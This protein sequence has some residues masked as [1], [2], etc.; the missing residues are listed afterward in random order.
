MIRT[1]CDWC[2]NEITKENEFKPIVMQTED[3]R[4]LRIGLS[5][6]PEHN[7]PHACVACVI[8]AF[9]SAVKEKK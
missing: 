9:N 5:H 4:E 2:G 1:Y 8:K 7:P 3:S 6:G